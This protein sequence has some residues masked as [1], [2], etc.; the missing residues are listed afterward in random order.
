MFRQLGRGVKATFRS[1]GQHDVGRLAVELG[2]G[3]RTTA[4]GVLLSM[5]FPDAVQSVLPRLHEMLGETP[6]LG[7][8]GAGGGDPFSDLPRAAGS[9]GV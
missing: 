9:G 5:E 2:G 6:L 1:K 7:L 8:N 3:G 4:A